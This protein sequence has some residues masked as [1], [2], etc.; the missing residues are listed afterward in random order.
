MASG[1]TDTT[2]DGRLTPSPATSWWLVFPSAL[3][4]WKRHCQMFVERDSRK[5]D[6]SILLPSSIG[7]RRPV[8]QAGCNK[9][10]RLSSAAALLL[11]P[12]SS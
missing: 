1:S 9:M 8:S 7:Q 2:L 12:G 4:D 6:R 3:P 10:G 5:T 11:A